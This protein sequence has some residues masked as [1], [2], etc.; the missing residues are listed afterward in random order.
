MNIYL[1]SIVGT[2][3]LAKFECNLPGAEIALVQIHQ[4]KMDQMINF[5]KNYGI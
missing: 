5:V 4:Q 1:W 3:V 2:F